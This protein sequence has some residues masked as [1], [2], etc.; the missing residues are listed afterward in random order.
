MPLSVEEVKRAFPA[1]MT[2]LAAR[3]L[4]EKV[5]RLS[6]DPETVQQIRENF[7]TY[8]VVLR[9]G[10]FKPEDYLNAVTYVSYKLMGYTNQESYERTF[11]QRYQALVARGASTKDISSHVAM[12][13]KN[14]L[15]NLV[16]E[17][18]MVPV[19]VLH[20]DAVQ[21]AIAT[22]LDLM[23]NAKSE[24]V[25]TQ[26]ANSLLTHLRPPERQDVSISVSATESPSLDQLRANFEQLTLRQRGL[27]ESGM[28]TREIAHLPLTG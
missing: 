3:D 10:R 27:I 11:P 9:D 20:Q 28:T 23:E 25:R 12:Y 18:S 19:W 5:S 16:L 15:V 17:R 26:A 24:M 22:L 2:D 8:S 7:L 21:R 6:G 14:K 1:G 4:A 13:N